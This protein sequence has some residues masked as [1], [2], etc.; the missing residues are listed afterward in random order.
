MED[1]AAGYGRESLDLELDAVDMS[2]LNGR[3]GERVGLS[4][5]PD[6]G[7]HRRQSSRPKMHSRSTSVS[8]S[9]VGT[10]DGSTRFGGEPGMEKVQ[11][12][13]NSFPARGS[14]RPQGNVPSQE[15][16]GSPLKDGEVVDKL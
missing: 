16:R 14:S 10:D 7:G 4:F 2:R 15:L 13:G 1:K 8:L 11:K 9:Y 3:N 12:D 6:H 5:G